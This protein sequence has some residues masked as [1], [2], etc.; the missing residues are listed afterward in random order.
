MKSGALTG[1]SFLPCLSPHD[2]VLHKTVCF[3]EGKSGIKR[4]FLKISIN[5]SGK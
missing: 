1:K 5:F 2:T 3:L 4:G